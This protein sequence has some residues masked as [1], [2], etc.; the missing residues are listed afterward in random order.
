MV[1]GHAARMKTT[2]CV[3]MGSQGG[4]L[5]SRGTHSQNGDPA[6]MGTHA[7]GPCRALEHSDA[8]GQRMTSSMA[9]LSDGL[10]PTSLPRLWLSGCG[11]QEG[12]ALC[13]H[14][15]GEKHRQVPAHIPM[16]GIPTGLFSP[17][18]P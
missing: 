16:A 15:E 10:A 14:I 2:D 17:P 6:G 4:D 11:R 9:Q 18:A 8:A 7:G 12:L 1:Q 5:G 3:G 13:G